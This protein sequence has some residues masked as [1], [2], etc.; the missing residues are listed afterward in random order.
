MEI[1]DVV[2][3]DPSESEF[4]EDGEEVANGTNG[5]EGERV[6]VFAEVSSAS[7]TKE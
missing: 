7:G 4:L 2:G 5:R 3:I 1:V 6:W